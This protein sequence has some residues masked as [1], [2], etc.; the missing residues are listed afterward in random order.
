[1]CFLH[2]DE[3]EN[4]TIARADDHENTQ[5]MGTSTH[6]DLMGYEIRKVEELSGGKKLFFDVRRF[7]VY[8]G[9]G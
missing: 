2:R 1:M 6:A 9:G 7:G 8:R 3:A 5:T 4:S